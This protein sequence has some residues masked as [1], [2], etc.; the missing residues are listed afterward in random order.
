VRSLALALL[1]VGTVAALRGLRAIPAAR[2]PFAW[3]H[4]IANLQRPGNPAR[5]ATLALGAGTLILVLL[6]AVEATL[7]RP[8][9]VGQGGDRG[10]LLLWDVQDD[11]EPGV[12]RR[13]SRSS[14]TRRSSGLPSSP[15]VW[16]R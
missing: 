12:V 6:V 11:Q 2:L 4:G 16:R 15:C 8:L 5:P 1:L 7:L 13:C 14:V 3:R 10:N 9:E